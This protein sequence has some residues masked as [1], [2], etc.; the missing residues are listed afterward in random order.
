MPP[1]PLDMLVIAVRDRPEVPAAAV[2]LSRTFDAE[3]FSTTAQY[4]V[5]AVKAG[6]DADHTNVESNEGNNTATVTVVVY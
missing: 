6:G 2:V 1:L 5:E 3:L 4:V